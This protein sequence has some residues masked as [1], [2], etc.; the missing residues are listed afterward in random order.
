M[1]YLFDAYRDNLQK[2]LSYINIIDTLNSNEI[3]R[4]TIKTFNYNS[5]IISL[6]GFFE[7]YIEETIRGYVNILSINIPFFKDIPIVIINNHLKLSVDKMNLLI[8]KNREINDVEIYEMISNIESCK[9]KPTFRLNNEVFTYHTSN[10]RCEILNN[11]FSKV[12]INNISRIMMKYY[13][14]EN[15]LKY[16]YPGRELNKIEDEVV[17]SYLE[18]L[19]QRRND[20]AHG[21]ISE[22]LSVDI[23]KEIIDFLL[24]LGESLNYVIYKNL[25]KNLYSY[26]SIK[27][28]N[29]IK[30]HNNNIICIEINELNINLGDIIIAKTPDNDILFSE[31]KELQVNRISYPKLEVTE[32]TCIAIKVEFIAK[33]NQEFMLWVP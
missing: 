4:K 17:Y 30:I 8:N 19:I 5:I 20:V 31:V 13:K 21:V 11:M 15:Y 25:Y 16:K 12:D 33:D 9:N 23:L 14:F 3:D 29:V 6:Y 24:I 1:L 22:I 26:K 32:N 28:N 7:R 10:I 2:L 27:L 18:D